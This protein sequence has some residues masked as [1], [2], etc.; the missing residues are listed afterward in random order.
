MHLL[1]CLFFFNSMYFGYKY[2]CT[3]HDNYTDKVF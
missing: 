2:I 1:K 3:L